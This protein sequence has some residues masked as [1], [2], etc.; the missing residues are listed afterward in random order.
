MDGLINVAFVLGIALLYFLPAMLGRGKPNAN[1]ICCLNFFFGWTFVGWVVAMVW[2]LQSPPDRS[3]APIGPIST[4]F[5]RSAQVD[6]KVQPISA[7]R[8]RHETP[9]Q[10]T[11]E[12]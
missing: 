6:R 2:S 9:V 11:A 12:G 4:W 7:H 1:A 8:R 3:S 5:A 10:P